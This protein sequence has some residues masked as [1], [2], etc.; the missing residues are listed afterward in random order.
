LKLK[1]HET[2]IQQYFQ[3][4]VVYLNKT[5]VSFDY[6]DIASKKAVDNW[7]NQGMGTDIVFSSWDGESESHKGRDYVERKIRDMINQSHI[8]LVLV[9]NN[10]HERPWV[11]YEVNH[12]KCHGMSVIWTQLPNTTGAPPFLLRGQLPVPFKMWS[13]QETVRANQ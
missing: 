10:T 9:G 8:V 6:K 11:N 13:L 4:T 2:L 1:T 7:A 12:A 3:R 5:V